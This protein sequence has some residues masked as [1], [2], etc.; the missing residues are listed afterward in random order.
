MANGSRHSM[1]YVA[2][3][4]YGQTPATPAFKPIRHTGTT[5]GLSK[6]SLQ[7][8]EI[9]ADRHIADFR[10]GASQV[11]GDIN[12]ELSFG[13]FDDLLEGVLLGTWTSSFTTGA[14]SLSATV[15]TFA[16]AAGSFITDGL[17]VGQTIIAS[18]F[19]NAG[20]NGRFKITA[21]TATS[22]TV[23]ALEGQTQVVEAAA[24]G[25]TL[26]TFAGKLKAGTVR[27]SFT[28]ERFF[29]DIATADKP[30]HRFA[31][32]ELNTLGLAISA[33]AMITG[34]IGTVGRS[35]KTDTVIVPGATYAQ[36]TTTS[37]LDSFTGTLNEAGT[38]IAVI[39][40]IQLNLENGLEARFVVGSKESI[41]PSI[42]RSNCSGTITAYFE[43]SLLLDKFINETESN[44]VF[45]LPDGA[46]NKYI[47]TL[48]R[49]K[50]NGG[51]PDVEGEGPVTLSMPFQALLDS[52]T[53]TNIQ[54]ERVPAP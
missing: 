54:I 19:T 40:E 35:L 7:S 34:T 50:Y 39:T 47:V 28:V 51:Q 46:G 42:G 44:I 10:H 36:P 11:G 15:G 13:S 29:G 24:T 52:V 53:Q 9:R 23:T 4:A 33:N 41:L 26:A 17:A 14:Q 5:L 38:P 16:R 45:E 2:E 21:L 30:Y 27:R 6:E 43:N 8:E 18:G 22:A 25:R 37:P 1:R 49:I 48:P 12:F 20:N 32:V 3:T 31:G